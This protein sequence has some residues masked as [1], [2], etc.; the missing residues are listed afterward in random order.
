MWFVFRCCSASIII[1]GFFVSPVWADGEMCRY[2]TWEWNTFTKQAENHRQVLKPYHEL[3]DEEIDPHSAC[4]ICESDQHW[5]QIGGVP[6]FRICKHFSSA[7]EATL[8]RVIDSGFPID[9]ISA[10]R[11][12]RTKGEVDDQGLR[13]RFSHHS[14]GTAIDINSGQNGLYSN[15][16]TFGDNFRGALKLN[17]VNPLFQFPEDLGFPCCIGDI[18]A[19]YK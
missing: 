10:Y 16:L 6:P 3:T 13:S 12:G 2:Q 15:C 1:A 17:P 9:S 11:V 7:V 18:T 5:V 19:I 8:L 14:F 4:T